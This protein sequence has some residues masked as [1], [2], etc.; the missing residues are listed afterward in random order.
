VRGLTPAQ[1]TQPLARI[2]APQFDEQA[3][4][5][6]ALGLLEL[7]EWTAGRE[8]MHAL[9]AKIPQS[10]QYRALL[11]YARGREAQG[12]GR[13]SDALAEYQRALQLDPA[14][15]LAKQAVAELQRRR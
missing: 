12:A 15:A 6:H 11:C 7:G 2:A 4:L 9:A 1:T 14:L 5:A 10:K 8:A 13:K 3:S